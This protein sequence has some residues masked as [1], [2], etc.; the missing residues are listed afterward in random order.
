MIANAWPR[1][2]KKTS[3]VRTKGVDASAMS[4]KSG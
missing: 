3:I 2:P 1:K 4:M